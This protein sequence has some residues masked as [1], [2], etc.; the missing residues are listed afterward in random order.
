[1]HIQE[2]S[3]ESSLSLTRYSRGHLLVST[4]GGPGSNWSRS[5]DPRALTLALQFTR[6]KLWL[7]N[8]P[9]F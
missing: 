6:V 4:E 7:R 5:W 2:R 1:M 8:L 3:G 9:V